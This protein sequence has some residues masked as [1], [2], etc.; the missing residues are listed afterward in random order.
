LD[1]ADRSSTDSADDAD[2]RTVPGVTT[3]V[4]IGAAATRPVTQARAPARGFAAPQ[5]APGTRRGNL[6]EHAIKQ[7]KSA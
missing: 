1:Y 6:T 7:T 2:F 5:S 4:L 3:L